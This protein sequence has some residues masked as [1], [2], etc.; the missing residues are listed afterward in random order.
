MEFRVLGPL[1]VV[2]DE[3][4]ISLGGGK[5]RALL[6]LLLLHA[7]E[8]VSRDR[9]LD[10]LWRE[11]AHEAGHSLDVQVARLR[12]ALPPDRLLTRAG[13]YVLRVEPGELDSQR[14]EELLQQGRAD[15]DLSRLREALA[16]W[17]GQAYA[18]VAYEDF[19]RLESARLEELRLAT[20][21]ARIDAELA[22]GRADALIPELEQLT[23]RHPLRERLRGQLMLALY[24]SGRQVEA[25]QVYADVR[26]R[27]V[28]ELG[29]EP[30]PQ[31]QQLERAIL[32]QDPSLE[33]APIARRRSRRRYLYAVP[34]AA[35]VVVAAVLAATHGSNPPRAAATASPQ[36]VAFVSASTRKLVRETPARAIV[37]ER[38]G[39]GS[40]WALAVDG[41]LTR[42][43][44]H[45]GNVLATIGTGVVPNG[46]AAGLGSVW[47]TDSGSPTLLRID[48]RQNVVAD[49]I[50]LPTKDTQPVTATG[51]VVTGD[52]SVWVGQG[53]L[54]PFSWLDRIDPATGR[55]EKRILIPGGAGYGD[56]IAYANG[57]VWVGG[58]GSRNV[59]HVDP[60]TNSIVDHAELDTFVCCVAAG[61]GYGWAITTDDHTVW[62]IAPNGSQVASYKLAARPE[63]LAYSDGAVWVAGGDTGAVI[64]IDAVTGA[65]RR[66]VVGHHT[67][68]MAVANGVVAAGVQPTSQDV[69]ATVRG[70]ALHVLLREQW[71]SATDPVFTPSWNAAASQLA[72]ATCARL[73]NYRD[74]TGDAGRKLVPELAAGPPLV[75]NGGRT[76][77]IRIRPGF[78]FSPPSDESV[79]AESMRYTLERTLSPK[80]LGRGSGISLLS[81]VFGATE[82]EAGKTAHVAGLERRGDMLV[83]RLARPVPDLPRRLAMTAFCAVPLGTPALAN[84]VPAALPSAGPYYVA[85]TGGEATVVRRN[86]NYRGPRPHRVPTIVYTSDIEPGRAIA[87]IGGGKGDYVSEYDPA[88]ASDAPAARAAGSRYR[89]LPGTSGSYLALNANRPLFHNPSWRRAVQLGFNRAQFAALDFSRPASDLLPPALAG[90]EPDEYPVLGDVRAARKLTGGRQVH[91]VLATF[92]PGYDRG[93]ALHAR[94]LRQELAALGIYTTIVKL[95]F[96]NRDDPAKLAPILARSDIVSWNADAA[97]PDPVSYLRSLL[98]LTAADNAA[99]ARAA[100]LR[101]PARETAA[102]A[103]A[104]RLRARGTY[105]VYADGGLPVLVSRRVGCVVQQPEYP[106]LDLAAMCL[107]G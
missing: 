72:Y 80:L 68:G 63:N 107:K 59:T 76:Y 1:E 38:F 70:P 97:Y 60:A 44:P 87:L 86:P 37:L 98:Y 35:A 19:A 5:Q 52:G 18:D 83:I 85:A 101:S 3:G 75:S 49:K 30:G 6:A 99:L 17:R 14:F 47:V 92:D 67:I 90:H 41:E 40:L 88:L 71:L 4:P 104:V 58:G 7:N 89:L 11:R 73:Y 33:A 82:F 13:G 32:R 84:G 21:E 36:S 79:T 64:R 27:L 102:A 39:F 95:T 50:G 96:D 74:A 9:L 28:D 42:I 29:L 15:G 91:A 53:Q 100:R 93:S 12:K 78:R 10:E 31:L 103:V 61:G 26:K 62:K 22:S 54:N 25:L 48:P 81:D 56:E 105:V 106:G 24:R 16:L 46:L 51:G 57:Q 65:R 43:D 2:G 94:I 66:Y 69:L 23:A 8:V 77:R 20:V 55:V 45:T 34:V